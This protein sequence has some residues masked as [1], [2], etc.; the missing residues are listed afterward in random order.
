MIQVCKKT[1]NLFGE[2]SVLLSGGFNLESTVGGDLVLPSVFF[3]EEKKL[4]GGLHNCAKK[5]AAHMGART[6]RPPVFHWCSWYYLYE[7]LDQQILE[8]YM[9]AF[10]KEQDIPF[11]YI[12][13]DAGYAPGLGG[14]LLPSHRFPEGLKKAAETIER[15]GYAPG[16]AGKERKRVIYLQLF[17]SPTTRRFCF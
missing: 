6:H 4:A 2:E 3:T 14:W 12:Q 10:K 13:I 15:A 9:D 7:N 8:E 1:R 17:C 16:M 5:I 11:C